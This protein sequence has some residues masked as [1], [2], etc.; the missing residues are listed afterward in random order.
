MLSFELLL[1]LSAILKLDFMKLGNGNMP[2]KFSDEAM[3]N[4]LGHEIN[5]KFH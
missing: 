1:W 3:K 4:V 5:I 2:R